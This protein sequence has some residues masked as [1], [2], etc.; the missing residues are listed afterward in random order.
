MRRIMRGMT[1]CA[2]LSASLIAPR[3]WAA[4]GICAPTEARSEARAWVERVAAAP[5]VDE[6]RRLA[7]QP[8]RGAHFALSQARA[9]APWTQS[10]ADAD[11]ALDGYEARVAQAATPDDVA[12]E[13]ATLVSVGNLPGEV[14]ADLGDGGCDFSTGEVIATVLGFILG[15]IPG[16]I[17]LFL[18]C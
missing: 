17:L 7:T 5:S 13:L 8:M 3:T 12:Q 11:A 6:A 16:I 14:A 9:V 10:L 18:L 2:V 15:I 4:E 1:I